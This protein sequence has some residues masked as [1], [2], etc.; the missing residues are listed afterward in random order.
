MRRINRPDGS[1]GG[2][3]SASIPLQ[4]F[5]GLLAKLELG[6]KG[7]VVLR[8]ADYGMIVRQPP[9]PAAAA[10]TVGSHVIPPELRR[11]VDAGQTQGTYITQRTSD[12]NERTVSFRRLPELPFTLVVGLATEDYLGQVALR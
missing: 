9:S 12:G 8:G 5:Q 10:G 3:V 2:I 11:A 6:P 4:H 7:V 1:F